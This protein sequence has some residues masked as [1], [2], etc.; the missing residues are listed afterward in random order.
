MWRWSEGEKRIG[1]KEEYEMH[2][3]EHKWCNREDFFVKKE[4]RHLCSISSTI[5]ST[6]SLKKI[7]QSLE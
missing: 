2:D 1:C 6:A 7:L 5:T 4:K 3:V